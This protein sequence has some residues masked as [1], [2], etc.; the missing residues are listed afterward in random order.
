MKVQFLAFRKF[1]RS[2]MNRQL[3][4][5][6]R[7]EKCNYMEA[8][9]FAKSLLLKTSERRVLQLIDSKQLKA[10]NISQGMKKPRW[11]ILDEHLEEFR[12][13]SSVPVVVG[14]AK[15]FV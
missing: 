14:E 9:Q 15:Q 13:G 8:K 11:A 12:K 6:Q 3:I 10:R 2:S 7:A 4:G 5:W 1:D